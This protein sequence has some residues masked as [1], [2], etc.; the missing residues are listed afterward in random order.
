MPRPTIEDMAATASGL[1]EAGFQV[2]LERD[3]KHRDDV[4]VYERMR[5]TLLRGD[6]ERLVLEALQYPDGRASFFLELDF[7]G[8]KTHSFPLDSWKLWPERVEF[9]YYLHPETGQGLTFTL[10]FDPE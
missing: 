9:K 10:V 2:S 6:T 1:A 3:D 8:L 7:H 5:W 4:L